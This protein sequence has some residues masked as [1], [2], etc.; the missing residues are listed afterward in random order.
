MLRTMI[1]AGA[2]LAA[3]GPVLSQAFDE[4]EGH[5]SSQR[6]GLELTAD[7]KRIEGARYAVSLSTMT[8]MR[9]DV[10]GCGGEIDGEVVLT[11]RSGVLRVPEPNTPGLTP[12][13]CEIELRFTAP[14]ELTLQE[15]SGCTYF[16]GA[17]CEFTGKVTH[18]AAG[19]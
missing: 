18:D 10:G 16:H 7:L 13:V 15:K 1:F 5:Y 11:G 19:L 14:Y 8:P 12:R 9:G 17:A 3:S 2:I 6:P 4:L